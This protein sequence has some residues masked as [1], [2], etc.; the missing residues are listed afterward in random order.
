M[1]RAVEP[2]SGMAGDCVDIGSLMSMMNENGGSPDFLS[3]HRTEFQE[4]YL[5]DKFSN[6]K[7]SGGQH[8][9]PSAE[10]RP[11]S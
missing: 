7:K 3:Y 11:S 2:T 8:A 4:T 5:T 9:S 10:L 6:N 1:S